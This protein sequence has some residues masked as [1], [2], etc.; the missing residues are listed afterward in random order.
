MEK[1]RLNNRNERLYT[2]RDRSLAGL[3]QGESSAVERRRWFKWRRWLVKFLFVGLTVGWAVILNAH[4]SATYAAYQRGTC[5]I[6]DKQVQ[7]DDTKDKSGNVT[8]R[9][10]TPV[11]SYVVHTT[12]GGQALAGGFDGPNSTEYDD[13]NEADEIVNA[14]AIGQNTTC[15][16]NPDIPS[17][18]FLVFYGYSSSDAFFTIFLNVLGFGIFAVLVYLL[19]DWTIWRLYALNKRGVLTEGQVLRNEVR[20]T[21]SR[22][23]TV[24]I[25]SY[26]T[27]EEAT[28][29]RSITIAKELP[30]GSPVV[31]CYDPFYPRYRRPDD[32]PP[33]GACLAGAAFTGLLL[34]IALVVMVVLWLVP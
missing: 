2:Y 15:W 29:E 16:Y 3:W 10:Y 14:Y 28:K 17:H 7:E 24:S 33:Q 25:V 32:W 13:P 20:R 23:Y 30:V 1:M 4:Y 5:T 9:S 27:A 21:R 19:F 31:I 22:S 26:Y 34:M 11:F 6:T 8:S 12:N 18:A